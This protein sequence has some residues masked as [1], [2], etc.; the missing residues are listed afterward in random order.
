MALLAMA[1]GHGGQ[2][3]AFGLQIFHQRIKAFVLLAQQGLGA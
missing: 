3:D 2:S 1:H